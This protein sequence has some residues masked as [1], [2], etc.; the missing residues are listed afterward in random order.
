M[1]SSI[2]LYNERHPHRPHSV[3]SLDSSVSS[4]P[5]SHTALVPP[6][7]GMYAASPPGPLP[8]PPQP[9]G[10]Q[11]THLP[12]LHSVSRPAA[13]ASLGAYSHAYGNHSTSPS[14]TSSV[15]QGESAPIENGYP[16]PGMS[17]TH[18]SGS[19]SAQK[20]AYRQRRKDPSCDACR[21]RKVK[22][23]FPDATRVARATLLWTSNTDIVMCIVRRYGNTKLH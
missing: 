19:L 20:R 9:R 4:S 12:A 10:Q 15:F 11:Q 21:E 8:P 6:P 2:P 22:V 13:T 1:N 23:S 7:A 14:A 18:L 16:P 3:G 5:S 17:P